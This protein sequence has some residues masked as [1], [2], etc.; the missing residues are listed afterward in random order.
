MAIFQQELRISI[1]M[2]SLKSIRET[3]IYFLCSFSF[4]LF[5]SYQ[6]LDYVENKLQ[7]SKNLLILFGHLLQFLT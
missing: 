5:T 3:L 4:Y 6:F 7:G 1:Y 2:M